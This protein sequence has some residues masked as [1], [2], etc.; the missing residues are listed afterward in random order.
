MSAPK[1]S[2]VMPFY[3]CEK[4]LDDSISSILSQ[5]FRDIEYIIIDD[6][7]TDASEEIVRKYMEKDTR[8]QYIRN[9]ENK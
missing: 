8:I 3:N 4:Y 9:P 5:T 7:S 6:A 1:I 2:V